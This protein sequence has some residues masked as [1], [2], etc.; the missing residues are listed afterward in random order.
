MVAAT[1]SDMFVPLALDD[2]KPTVHIH[3]GQKPEPKVLVEADGT[4]TVEDVNP[5]LIVVED[6]DQ[7]FKL[8]NAEHKRLV[9]SS[10]Q[11]FMDKFW[12][13]VRIGICVVLAAL[14]LWTVAR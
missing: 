3:V 5:D 7:A 10:E 2:K 11:A 8:I 6:H 9:E 12:Y 13:G 1:H 4:K 14:A